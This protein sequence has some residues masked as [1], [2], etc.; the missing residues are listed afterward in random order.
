MQLMFLC[1]SCKCYSKVKGKA[2]NRYDLR[3]ELGGTEVRLQC[4]QCQS[5]QLIHVNRIIAQ[6]SLQKGIFIVVGVLTAIAFA[7][8][9]LLNIG[10]IS[11]ATFAIPLVFYFTHRKQQEETVAAFNRIQL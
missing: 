6:N 9:L 8:L 2:A 11:T 4:D 10:F 7:T 5:S 1:K 3:D